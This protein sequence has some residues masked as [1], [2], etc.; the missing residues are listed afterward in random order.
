MASNVNPNNKAGEKRKASAAVGSASSL[1]KFQL[2]FTQRSFAPSGLPNPCPAVPQVPVKDKETN[3]KCDKDDTM[4]LQR[5]LLNM[6]KERSQLEIEKLK[7]EKEK[8]TLEIAVLKL[9]RRKIENEQPLPYRAST[10]L[11]ESTSF[12]SSYNYTQ[13]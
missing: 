5:E 13:L 10:P 6:E 2:G 7:L 8:L 12:G 1:T 9:K 4:Q 11:H 3:N